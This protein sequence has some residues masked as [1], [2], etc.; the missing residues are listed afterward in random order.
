VLALQQ[1]KKTVFIGTFGALAVM[2][3]RPHATPSRITACS[4]CTGAAHY[5]PVCPC[6]LACSSL[7]RQLVWFAYQLNLSHLVPETTSEL[8]RKRSSPAC[9]RTDV[10]PGGEDAASVYG[11][12]GT[13]RANM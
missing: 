6:T 4:F 9:T 7:A 2:T 13:Q 12:T 8:P 11:C 1:D 5:V 3:A 10:R